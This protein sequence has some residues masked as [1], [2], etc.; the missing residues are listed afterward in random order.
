MNT[1]KVT[2]PEEAAGDVEGLELRSILSPEL[3]DLSTGTPAYELFPTALLRDAAASGICD[4]TLPTYL[5][6]GAGPGPERFRRAIAEWVNKELS[7]GT[8]A[9]DVVRPAKPSEVFVTNGASHGVDLV[10]KH[11]ARRGDTVLV[12]EI[13]Y[14]L[15]FKIFRDHGLNVV[16][17]KMDPAT[18]ID[19]DDLAAKIAAH[20]PA[21]VY[22]IPTYHNPTGATVPAERRQALVDIVRGAPQPCYLVADEVYQFLYFYT[23]ERLPPPPLWCYDS[24]VV[25]SLNSFSKLL[26]PG[27]RLG[28]IYTG[29][30]RVLETLDADGV[31]VSGGGFNPFVSRIVCQVVASG[32][33]A[34]HVATLRTETR[35]RAEAFAAALRRSFPE[36]SLA[37]T[38]PEGGYFL[39]ATLSSAKLSDPSEVAEAA[40]RMKTAFRL[41]TDC[42]V[43]TPEAKAAAKRSMRL[44]FAH[45]PAER[46]EVGAERLA[47]TF[48][49]PTK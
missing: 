7:I 20:R 6:Y 17:V 39:W 13:T 15:M 12:E 3:V 8:C 2:S 11:F 28:W 23:G 9:P 35:K 36:G 1:K 29:S 33:L 22:V 14:F 32:A 46:L 37:F 18:G 25:I 43:D 49:S 40:L 48:A 30:R 45:Y 21:F 34:Q 16:P 24:E 38:E 10:C 5:Q 27:L 31:S 19:L 26:A 41:G 47:K 44:C 4:E 42:A